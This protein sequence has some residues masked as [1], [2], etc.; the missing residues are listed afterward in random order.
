MD[1]DFA[2]IADFPAGHPQCDYRFL[3]HTCMAR[4]TGLSFTTIQKALWGLQTVL[5]L[6]RTVDCCAGGLTR[7][8]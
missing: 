3:C 4:R 2:R 6:Q 5:E 7:R 1:S 8:A